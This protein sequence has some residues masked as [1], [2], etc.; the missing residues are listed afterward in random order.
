MQDEAQKLKLSV[1]GLT[2]E[3]NGK[4]IMD[5]PCNC[6][7]CNQV[8][9]HNDMVKHPD[10]W[11][12]LICES[13]HDRIEEE[14]NSGK[15]IDSSGNTISWIYNPDDGLITFFLDSVEISCWSTETDPEVTFLDFMKTWNMAQAAVITDE[16]GDGWYDGFLKAQKLNEDEDCCLEDIKPDEVRNM[17][18]HAESKHAELKV[19][20]VCFANKGDSEE[21]MAADLSAEEALIKLARKYEVELK[22]ESWDEVA[23]EI[24]AKINP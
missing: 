3:L 22:Y 2:H 20:P 18:E 14:N 17:S 19:K 7:E 21:N 10:D 11:N 6:P 13:C 12:N 24:I 4:I 8:V 16:F 9:E 15:T 1:F 23:N 5:M